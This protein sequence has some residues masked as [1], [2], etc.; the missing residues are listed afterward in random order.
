MREIF[1]LRATTMLWQEK[2][3]DERW[4]RGASD[5]QESETH[6]WARAATEQDFLPVAARI[7]WT[8][9]CLVLVLLYLSQNIAYLLPFVNEISDFITL[10][11]ANESFFN[12][13][14]VYII[15]PNCKNLA[16]AIMKA[17]SM[18]SSLRSIGSCFVIS[19]RIFFVI[20]RHMAFYFRKSLFPPLMIKNM[21]GVSKVFKLR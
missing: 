8:L 11:L 17:M 9:V 5:C 20:G 18:F 21:R 15:L 3:P 10:I 7:I 14:L 13:V 6:N 19:L 16:H 4:N 1:F 2:T 12:S